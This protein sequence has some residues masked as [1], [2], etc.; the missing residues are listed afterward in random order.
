RLL[1]FMDFDDLDV[2]KGIIA[3]PSIIIA[4]KESEV[5]EEE[6]QYCY[7]EELEQAL[8]AYFER[9]KRPFLQSKM[10]ED[11]W[12]FLEDDIAE[13]QEKMLNTY[14]TLEK[15]LGKPKA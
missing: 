7:F 13:L 2:F 5:D 10:T 3:Y 4:D 12:N 14:D 6:I 1:Y 8:E 11:V 9:K 15:V